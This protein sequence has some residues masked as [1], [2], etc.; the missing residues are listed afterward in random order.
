MAPVL[1]L[2]LGLH[3]KPRS[4]LA[5]LS[6]LIAYVFIRRQQTRAKRRSRR[7]AAAAAAA[8][9]SG[10][11]KGRDGSAKPR[12]VG[13]D[14]HFVEQ[15]KKLLPICIPG[16]ASKEAGLLAALA[17]ILIAR[18]WLDVWFSG[19]NGA[20][21]KAIVS[22]D[23]KK[24]IAKAIIE[25]GLM[26]WP[27]SIVNNSLK[28]T[29]SAL[30]LSFRERLTKFAH[31]QYLDGIT[32]YK[33]S[34]ID[35]RI[36]NADQLLTQDIDKFADN[37]SHLY[38]DIAKPLVDIVLFA[39]KLGEAIGGE[40]PFYMIGYFFLS[41]VVLRALS[42]PFGKYTAVEQKLEGDFR[43][44]H[45]RIIAH[46]E[47]I[48]F[49]N[50]AEREKEGVN[51]SFDKIA[52][53]VRKVYTMRFANGILDSVLVKYCATMTAYYLLARPVF[54]PSYATEHMG[55]VSA[56]P[57]K[58]VE[59]Y[60][61]NSGYL[62]NLSQAV[63]RLILA[64]RDLTRFAGYTSRV[65]ELFEVLED[66]KKGRYERTMVTKSEGPSTPQS[67][68][69]NTNDLKGKVVTQDGVIIFD[70]VPIVTPN[71]DVLLK[72][73]SFKVTKGTD[74]IIAGPNGC[75]KSSLFRILGDL[76]PLFGGTVTK[77]HPSKLFYV[78]QKPYLALGTFRDQVIYPDTKQ[79]ALAKGFTDQKLF[80]LLSVVHL[81]YLIDRE[82]GWN[83]VQDWADV[84][85]GGEKQR[86]AMARLFYHR[87]Q[88]AILDECTSAVSIDVE[89]IMYE[90][91]RQSGITL[92]TVSHRP[93]LIRYH[94]Y[95][96]RFDG[97]GNYQFRKLDKEDM[98]QTA[99]GFGH[100]KSKR[101]QKLEEEDREGEDADTENSV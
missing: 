25:F 30:A 11:D 69:V 12:R 98:Q 81:G 2:P 19:L 90:H 92:F 71:N 73:L 4:T 50:G 24:F 88:F 62:V 9:A 6:F 10:A 7:A 42:P 67:Q 64:G 34:N 40:A 13:V 95:L 36:Q 49:Y 41:G 53:H 91:A 85:S 46:S 54:D 80:E 32:F 79:Q 96:L 44:A 35:N 45:S 89:G 82:G 59:D 76:W 18:T 100:G 77:P 94:E 8:A 29:I 39:Y 68:A 43:F 22:R 33:I 55:R 84:L 93:S 14:K 70:K 16:L 61:R 75:G 78:P 99:F 37:L 28:F 51:S 21:V 3:R 65:S 48:A 5:G 66:I 60:S 17:T 27:M 52:R 97:E 86:V 1:S 23:R 26:M 15:L 38:S 63:G 20:V 72:E 56:D 47:E 31:S 58:I 101:I 87:P 83:S 74:V 57:T